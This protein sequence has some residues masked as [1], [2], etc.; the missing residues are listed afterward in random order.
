MDVLNHAGNY[1]KGR[2]S[3]Y[4]FLI[5]AF[6]QARGHNKMGFRPFHDAKEPVIPS[7]GIRPFSDRINV[8][9]DLIESKYVLF[10]GD[11]LLAVVP[12]TEHQ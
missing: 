7:I 11:H 3:D 1:C 8:I 12:D 6:A 4:R 2:E 9:A 10:I 5:R